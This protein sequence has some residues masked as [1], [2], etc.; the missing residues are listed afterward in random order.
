MSVRAQEFPSP[1]FHIRVNMTDGERWHSVESGFGELLLVMPGVDI[2][3]N[4]E[5]LSGG[6]MEGFGDCCCCNG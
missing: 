2:E 1:R 5:L 3:A 6:A 4:P